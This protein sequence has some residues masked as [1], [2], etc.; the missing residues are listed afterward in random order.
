METHTH[1]ECCVEIGIIL[2]Q[3]D[4]TTSSKKRGRGQM[5]PSQPSEGTNPADALIL[6]FQPPELRDNRFPSFKSP[7]QFVVLG[8]SNPRG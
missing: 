8:Y 3:T 1:T 4:G 7:T 6:D 2:P 5:L